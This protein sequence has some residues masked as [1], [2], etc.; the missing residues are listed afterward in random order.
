VTEI[1]HYIIVIIAYTLAMA[2]EFGCVKQVSSVVMKPLIMSSGLAATHEDQASISSRSGPL[3]GQSASVRD[4]S[5]RVGSLANRWPEIAQFSAWPGGP[6]C[7][8]EWAASVCSLRHSSIPMLSTRAVERDGCGRMRLQQAPSSS[9]DIEKT[10]NAIG[11]GRSSL[12]V[13]YPVTRA[14]SERV[15]TRNDVCQL[16]K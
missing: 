2:V 9:Y 14:I 11:F 8:S 10:C 13:I 12:G 1:R 4:E 6:G 5:H 15:R 7:A 3:R 16:T